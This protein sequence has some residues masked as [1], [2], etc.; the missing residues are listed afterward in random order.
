[1]K[2]TLQALCFFVILLGTASVVMANDSEY[3]NTFK[4]ANSHYATGEY[5]MALKLYQ[6]L[7]DDENVHNPVLYLNLGNAYY[8][9]GSMGHAIHS[10]RR[11]TLLGS[12][13]RRVLENLEQN[14]DVTRAQ[15]SDR[16][17]TGSENRQ[18]IF[19]DANGMLFTI[20][21]VID[22]GM[23]TTLFLVFWLM[24]CGSLILRR[25]KPHMAGINVSAIT[26]GIASLLFGVMLWGQSISSDDATLGVVVASDIS[27]QEAPH[28][29]ANGQDIPE[30]M[31]VKVLD[32]D[33]DWTH[34]ELANGR[35]GFVPT[36]AIA[37]L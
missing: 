10:Y 11:G 17:R 22:R 28:S 29:E 26:V 5:E 15:L 2:K 34:V 27:L 25:M 35:E 37:E 30:G 13:D 31:E 4:D 6:R 9:T 23:L 14:I 8:R 12:S 16:Y 24:F 20:T 19:E 1:M 7:A 3:G 36:L 33:E 18:F 32:R 21:H